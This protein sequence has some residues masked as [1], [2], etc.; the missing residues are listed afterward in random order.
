MKIVVGLGNPGR[1]YAA[2]RHNLGFQV[3]DEI[4]RRLG[5][6]AQR[7]RFRAELAEATLDGEKVILVKPQT[8]MNLS[9]SSVRETL[10]WYKAPLEDLLVIVDDIDLPFAALRLR[11]AGGSG[12]HNGLKSIISDLG[13]D[14]F[15][16]LRVGIGR[17]AGEATRQVLSRFAP[18]EQRELP[19]LIAAA[20]TCALDWAEYGA[21]AAMNR[22][23]RRPPTEADNEDTVSCG[24]G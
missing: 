14:Q 12:G 22:C 8:Y 4:G 5:A 10:R 1:E 15:S 17:G 3:V 11:E 6:R 19:E 9:G 7:A 18:D 16:R 24:S 23:N 13:A 2:T 21:I 20:T